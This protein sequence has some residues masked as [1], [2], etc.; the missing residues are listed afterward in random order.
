[1]SGQR[2][3]RAFLATLAAAAVVA[4]GLPSAAQA[5]TRSAARADAPPAR[6][7]VASLDTSGIVDLLAGGSGASSNAPAASRPAV[8][9]DVRTAVADRGEVAVIVRYRDQVDLAAAESRAR[10]AA[11][12]TGLRS[13][14]RGA[15]ESATAETA[16]AAHVRSV[17]T[18]LRDRGAANARALADVLTDVDHVVDL[19]AIG[20]FAG[21]VDADTLDELAAHPDVASVELDAEVHLPEP[22]EAAPPKLP[23][24]SLEA[25]RAPPVWGDLGVRGENVV[26]GVMDSGV[27]G[28]HPALAD[29]Y[30]GRDGD[31]SDSWF[32][33]TGEPYPTPGDGHGHGTHVSGS[34]LGAPPG[35]VTGV[36]PGAEWIAAKIFRDNGAASTSG[37]HASFQ[38][39]LAPGGDPAKAPDVV[40]N[41]WGAG[42]PTITEFLGDVRAWRAAGIVPVFAAGNDGPGSGTIG[43][44]GSFPESI[45][46]GATDSGDVAAGF[47]S[48]G[49][50]VWDGVKHGKPDVSAPGQAIYSAWPT[51]LPDGPY[52]TISGTSMAT[53]HVTGVTAL[54]LS[55]APGLSV[56]Q[57]Q[58]VL[59]DTARAEQH[60]GTVPNDTYGAGIVDAQA[61]V[62]HAAHSGVVTG[63]V[64]GPD[65]PVAA[66]VE[67]VGDGGLP[68][69]TVADADSG[70]YRLVVRE[71]N[72]AVRVSAVGYTTRTVQVD[73]TRDATS[74][75]DVTLDAAPAAVLTGTVTSGGNAVPDARVSL[76]EGDVAPVWTDDEGRYRFD[77][78]A[79]EWTL[80]V[81][82]AGHE[83]A[84]QTVTV[85]GTTTHNVRLDPLPGGVGD[86]AWDTHL[87]DLARTG[88]ADEGAHAPTLARAWQTELG[89]D[90]AFSSPVIADGRAYVTTA[91]GRLHALDVTTGERTWTYQSGVNTRGTPTVSGGTV[92]IGGGDDRTLHAIDAATGERR[93]T[94]RA[95]DG[96]LTYATPAVVDGSVLITTGW[97]PDDGGFVHSIDTAT[98]EKQWVTDVGAQ[99]FFGPAVSAGIAVAA[100]VDEKRLTGLDVATGEVRWTYERPGADTFIGSPS[101]AGGSVYAVTT[102]DNGDGVVLALDAATGERRWETDHGDGQGNTPVVFGDAVIAGTHSS[103]LL[104]AYDRTSGKRLWRV[105]AGSAVTGSTAVTADGYVLLGTQITDQVMAV[106]AAT[107]DVVWSD[108]LTDSVLST[109]A[110][111]EGVLVA[112]DASG[113]LTAWTPTGTLAGTVA[114]PDGPLKAEIDDRRDRRDGRSGRG[115]LLLPRP[116]PRQLDRRGQRLRLWP[117]TAPGRD[118]RGADDDPG[119]RPRASRHGFRHRDRAWVGRLRGRRRA[120]HA[121][122]DRCVHDDGGRRQLHADRRRRRRLGPPR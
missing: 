8:P 109:P 43:S 93:W 95:G 105:S 55:A 112:V 12:T 32:V 98:G 94:Y 76:D 18:E 17:V 92:Y 46:V 9:D 121:Q 77:L 108:T 107:G 6:T 73:V 57:V 64:T 111:D 41:S 122:G 87:G 30:R 4:G 34:V 44:P 10:G 116:P 81:R 59:E 2:P 13:A 62:L 90:T 70:A 60:M 78:T 75:V 14:R 99:S 65:G 23:T 100:S 58:E 28:E 35:E 86:K 22:V 102:G 29:S 113:V 19:W 83:P 50:V 21:T 85:Q 120:A 54:L 117:A 24:W 42:D 97:G 40:N 68:A 67:V 104:A 106:D 52:H 33:S 45:T 47:S 89:G 88:L 5:S 84:S 79:G 101:I 114:G 38:W 80:R 37:I 110:Y 39:M 115:R 49:P 66:T 51:N 20:G 119:P 3:I 69:S 16:R 63:T 71:G 26:V 48:R 53:P 72:R 61:A 74:V 103:G 25:V 118:R 11:A 15:P 36:A 31:Q 91:D 96:R 1:M 7:A 27:D 82:A 56:D